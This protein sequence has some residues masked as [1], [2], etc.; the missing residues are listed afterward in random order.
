[1]AEMFRESLED[2]CM[3]IVRRPSERRQ[4]KPLTSEQFL[5]ACV[6]AFVIAVDPQTGVVAVRAALE[7]VH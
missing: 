4:M 3:K 5:I 6:L 1:M 2:L 7:L